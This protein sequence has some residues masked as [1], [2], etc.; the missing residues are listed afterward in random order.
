MCNE[1]FLETNKLFFKI[2]PEL[3]DVTISLFSGR[4]LNFELA[5]LYIGHN[6]DAGTFTETQNWFI[7]LALNKIL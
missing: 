2:L 5:Y 4:I 3:T 7:Y 1:N 6:N